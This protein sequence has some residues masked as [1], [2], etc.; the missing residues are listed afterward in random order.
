MSSTENGRKDFAASR[1]RSAQTLT[2]IVEFAIL[3]GLIA[4]I[5]ILVIIA[6]SATTLEP[7]TQHPYASANSSLVGSPLT[8]QERTA[9]GD[10]PLSIEI[11]H[12]KN[13]ED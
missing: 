9:R 10:I 1:N 13:L 7:A 6:A 8:P 4:A 12:R 2:K 5:L 11:A 3:T